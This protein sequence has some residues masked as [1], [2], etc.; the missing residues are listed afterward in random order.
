VGKMKT[1]SITSYP[2]DINGWQD[3]QKEYR[4]GVFLI[5]PPDPPRSR[6]D[7]LRGKYDPRGQAVCCTHI[8]LTSPLTRLVDKDGW[9]ELEGIAAKIKPVMIQYGPIANFLPAP[10]LYISVE[11]GQELVRMYEALEKARV[12][13]GCSPHIAN[14]KPH[15][16]IT[17]YIAEYFDRTMT[18]DQMRNQVEELTANL[19]DAVPRG[20]FLCSRLSYAVPDEHFHFT[21]RALL[22]LKGK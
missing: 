3:W 11:P 6:M 8:S 15:M 13:H 18:I 20:S 16:T 5:I 4:Y 12:F 7:V 2:Q 1:D 10:V 9:V 21:E 22:V 17:E 14:W 19:K